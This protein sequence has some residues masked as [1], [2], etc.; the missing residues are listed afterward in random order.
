MTA[1]AGDKQD[2]KMLDK[3]IRYLKT[4]EGDVVEQGNDFFGSLGYYV[5]LLLG[6]LAAIG[7]L[8]YRNQN[9]KYNADVVRVRSRRAGKI[10]AKR[11]VMAKKLL[12]ANDAKAFYEAIFRGIYGYL[13]DKLNISAANLDREVISA[14]LVARGIDEDIT[15]RLTDTLDLCEMAR[16]AP[17]T[18][19]S[20][21]EVFEKAKGVISDIED[22]I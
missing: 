16:Y 12:A 22:K 5:L 4:S 17:V 6:P 10:A 13:G 19:I 3:D 1:F 11:L 15:N 2:V 14:A 21:Q 7:A 9:R 8:V 18:H 20:Q